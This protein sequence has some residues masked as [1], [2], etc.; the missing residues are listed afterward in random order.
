MSEPIGEPF[1]EGGR[2]P[3]GSEIPLVDELCARRRAE[4]EAWCLRAILKGLGYSDDGLDRK[5]AEHLTFL[6]RRVRAQR[7]GE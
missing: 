5:I 6:K 1:G 7:P 2:P 3:T 4:Q